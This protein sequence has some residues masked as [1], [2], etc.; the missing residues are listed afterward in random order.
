MTT[1]STTMTPD[2]P[3]S[4]DDEALLDVL[5]DRIVELLEEGGSPCAAELVGERRHLL[6]RVDELIRLARQIKPDAGQPLPQVPGYT[7]L[8]ELGRGGM[9]AVFLARQDRLAGRLVALKALPPSVAL[10]PRARER[11]RNEAYAIARLSH[12]HI[13]AVHDVVAADGLHAYAMEWV[14]GE[15]LA[16][17]IAG[18]RGGQTDVVFVCRVGIAVAR[19]LHAVHLAGL[20]HRDV[21]PSNILLRRDGT[22]L[23]TDFGLA[24]ETDATLTQA[25]HFAGTVAYSPPEQLRGESERLDARSDV[26]ALGVTLYHALALRLPFTAER[27]EGV[28]QQIERGSA[29]ALRR[30]VPRVPL[31]LQTIVS[32]A[33]DTDPARRYATAAELADDLERVL[34]LQ[35]IRARPA[36]LLT[37]TVKLARRKRGLLAAG[38]VSAVLTAV[39]LAALGVYVFLVPGWAAWHV[40]E[41]RLALL[42][43]EQANAIIA[44]A[45]WCIPHDPQQWEPLRSEGSAAALDAAEPHYDAALRLAPFD[46]AIRAERNVLRA[47]RDGS[48]A[49]GLRTTDFRSRGL[50]AFLRND[51]DAAVELWSQFEVGRDLHHEPDPLVEAALGIVYLARDEPARAYPRLREACRNFPGV[52]FLVVYQADAALQCGDLE[53]AQ[54][55]LSAASAMPRLDPKGALERVQADLLAAQ[56]RDDEA[57]ALYRTHHNVLYAS[58]PAGLNFARFLESRGRLDEAL[59][60]YHRIVRYIPTG[61]KPR[62]AFLAG[63]NRWWESLS[64]I[65]RRWRIRAALE[66]RPDAPDSFVTL[67]R[68]YTWARGLALDERTG[69]VAAGPQTQ[70]SLP[71]TLKFPP[72]PA[73][74]VAV[75]SSSLEGL[76]LSDL[77]KRMRVQD[78]GFWGAVRTYPPALKAALAAAWSR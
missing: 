29:P 23:L 66:E 9:G 47:A 40:R 57:E 76:S 3:A 55:L 14:D 67:L 33:M 6:P 63:A 73:L 69:G 19:A 59:A 77:A 48:A 27:P 64:V 37:R 52:G 8:R 62:A 54:K 49:A 31:D 46:H 1:G 13:V 15:S 22:P 16:E 34:N 74:R 32:T 78:T 20:L 56:G 61:Q 10:S 18:R 51:I 28:V 44:T 75:S 58:G 30:V 26:Y 36:G 70:R 39:L 65:D 53:M 2:L 60:L 42:D 72:L 41:A 38:L 12:P 11:F 24:R 4:P 43:P 21:K 50:I 25:G 17:W 7:V 45:F 71:S 68:D 5:F 35:P